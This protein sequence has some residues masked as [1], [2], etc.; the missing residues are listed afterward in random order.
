MRDVDHRL[1]GV[2]TL[3]EDITHLAEISRLKSEFIADASHELRTPL[4]SVQMGIHLLLE[5]QSSTLTE[6]Q[7][8]I[9]QVCRD[10]TARL[11]R[12]MRE[13]LDLSKIES[14]EA[15]PVRSVVR[16]APLLR[17]TVEMLRLQV[18]A[19]PLALDVDVAPDLP[20]VFVDRAQIERVVGNLVTNA[21]CDAGAAGSPYRRQ[22][23][24]RRSRSRSIPASGFR[25]TTS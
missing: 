22:P 11:D 13:L 1:V 15:T 18:E 25:A 12:L 19:K 21:A 6:R 2:V 14:G 4:T 17:D 20:P 9:L 24:P 5:D 23:A 7:K 3:L 10:D 16:V 8:D